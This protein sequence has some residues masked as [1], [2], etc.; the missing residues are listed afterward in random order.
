MW[1]LARDFGPRAL[2]A[3][4]SSAFDSLVSSLIHQQVSMAAG[5]TIYGRLKT[6]C[7][8]RITPRRVLGLG[9]QGLRAC[10]VSRQKQG[11]ILDMAQKAASGALPLA[12]LSRRSDEEVERLLTQVKG[13]GPWTAKMFLLFHLQRPDVVAPQDL[14]LQMAASRA[15]DVSPKATAAFLV[16]QASKWSPYGSLASLVL[17]SSKDA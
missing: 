3:R 7:Q 12:S 1:R 2:D 6:A 16:S 17:W 15:Y 10:G 8:G 14:G 11:Y 5:R 9:P 4:P 13:I